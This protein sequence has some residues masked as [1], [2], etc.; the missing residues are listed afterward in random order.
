MDWLEF[1]KTFGIPVLMLAA[2]GWFG[3]KSLWPFIK[4]QVEAAQAEGKKEREAFLVA[5]ERRDQEFGKI[6]GE[7]NQ[8]TKAVDGLRM[9]IIKLARS[10]EE[11]K[12]RP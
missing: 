2:I 11:T 3:A 9:E 8:L 7:I 1:G 6:V 5:L 4:G 12:R 10:T